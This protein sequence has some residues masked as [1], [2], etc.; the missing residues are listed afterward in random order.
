MQVVTR[1]GLQDQ[2]ILFKNKKS[3]CKSEDK[4]LIWMTLEGI[5]SMDLTEPAHTHHTAHWPAMF[6]RVKTLFQGNSK[7]CV[8]ER[9]SLKG[10]FSL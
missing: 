5:C 3:P 9:L 6:W 10:L 7:A 2:Q 1:I 8:N 4:G